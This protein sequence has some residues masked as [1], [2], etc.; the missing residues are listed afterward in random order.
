M[1]I[2]DVVST[3][4]RMLLLVLAAAIVFGSAGLRSSVS[5]SDPGKPMSFT[6]MG[7]IISGTRMPYMMGSGIWDQLRLVVRDPETWANL[8]KQIHS[9]GPGNPP[10]PQAPP[11]PDIDFSREM[12]IVAAMGRRPSSNYSIIIDGAFA[13]E[14]N[15]RLEVMVR[16][17]ENRK[18]C[19]AFTVMT[20]PIDIVRLPK[21]DRTV[22]FR[23]T[24]VVPDCK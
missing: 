7:Q 9:L 18:G 21:T 17:V 24:E 22:L 13:Y 19:G 6:P 16:S 12:V 20:A 14:R 11:L 4:T 1:K 10:S 2:G 3:M 5:Q 23:E 8:W 15:Y